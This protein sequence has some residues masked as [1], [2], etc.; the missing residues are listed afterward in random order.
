MSGLL[1]LRVLNEAVAKFGIEYYLAHEDEVTL[2]VRKRVR[3][4][5]GK[6]VADVR[7]YEPR[8]G[9]YSKASS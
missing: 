4:L 2:W 9:G 3:E 7:P 1:V 6:P 8:N 5:E